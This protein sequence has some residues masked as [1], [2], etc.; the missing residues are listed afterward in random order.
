MTARNDVLDEI[1]ALPRGVN[2]KLRK[3]LERYIELFIDYTG[4]AESKLSRAATGDPAWVRKF[5]EG[6]PFFPDKYDQLFAYMDRF[7]DEM[8][9]RD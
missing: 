8:A 9:K 6:R 2:Q 3:D 7:I 5:R 4:I 1:R